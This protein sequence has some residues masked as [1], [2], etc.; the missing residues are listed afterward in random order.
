M[1]AVKHILTVLALSLLLSGCGIYSFSGIS[2]Q[3]DVQTITIVPVVNN[4]LKINPSLANDLTE[5]LKDQFRKMTRLSEEETDGDLLLEVIIQS[6]DITPQ[7]ITA[8]EVASQNRLTIT[9][10]VNFTNSKHDEDSFENKSFVAY[11]D[12]NS[13]LSLESVESQLCE[14]I[15]KT[16]V[17]DIFNASVAQW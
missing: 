17:E 4:A 5:A 9:A 8:N 11:A 12:Y 2:I 7:A 3:A 6:Y 14:E 16:L 13:E 1:R 10:R 15:I